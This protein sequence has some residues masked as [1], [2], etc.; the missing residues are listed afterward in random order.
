MIIHGSGQVLQ[1]AVMEPLVHL[2]QRLVIVDL[3]AKRPKDITIRTMHK[4]THEVQTASSQGN[5]NGGRGLT[6]FHV[7]KKALKAPHARFLVAVDKEGKVKVT[8]P[9]LFNGGRI[10]S[11]MDHFEQFNPLIFQ[12]RAGVQHGSN[13]SLHRLVGGGAH[14]LDNEACKVSR[15]LAVLGTQEVSGGDFQQVTKSSEPLALTEHVGDQRDPL[16]ET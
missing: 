7:V 4:G 16:P 9:S 1:G 13:L 3:G 5:L 11:M 8:G 14:A 12:L 6:A 2:G 15:D 10:Q